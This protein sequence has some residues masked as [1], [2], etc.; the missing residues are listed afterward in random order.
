[1][2]IYFSKLEMMKKNLSNKFDKELRTKDDF[3]EVL[4]L[5]NKY[6]ISGCYQKAQH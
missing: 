2:P 3:N 6:K 1:M 5:I 4:A